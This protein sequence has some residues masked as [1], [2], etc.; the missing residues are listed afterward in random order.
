[1]TPAGSPTNPLGDDKRGVIPAKLVLECIS[2]GAG[3][4]AL[5]V[6]PVINI[7]PFLK[8]D[9]GGFVGNSNLP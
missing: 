9:E 6:N 2:R 1:M 8:G 7:P 5:W 4:G 3:H